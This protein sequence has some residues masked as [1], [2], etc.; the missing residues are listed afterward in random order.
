V[1]EKQVKIHGYTVFPLDYFPDMWYNGGIEKLTPKEGF[2]RTC[3]LDN[4]TLS[5]DFAAG[6]ITSLI[7]NGME[8]VAAATPLFRVRLRDEAGQ[9]HHYTAYESG[10]RTET[11]TGGLYCD[12]PAP[13]E[14]AALGSYA[15]LAQQYLFYYERYL[16]GQKD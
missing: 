11:E 12:F 1:K 4:M 7:I 16:G 10:T 5:V 13:F 6:H 15:G 14:A 2:M 3:K 9:A 8:R